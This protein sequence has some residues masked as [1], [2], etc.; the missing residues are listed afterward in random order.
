M[1][2][3]SRSPIDGT[4]T[5]FR[6]EIESTRELV[7]T[8][9][10]S[11]IERRHRAPD[12]RQ[13]DFVFIDSVD[14]VNV[15]ALTDADQVVLI[16]QYRHGTDA[17]TVEVPGGMVDRGEA[18][19]EACA[20][21]LLEETGF[22]GEAPVIIGRVTPNPAIQGNLCHTGLVRRARRVA[23][24][25]PDPLENIRVRLFPLDDVVGLIQRGII[26]HALVVAAFYHLG[27]FRGRVAL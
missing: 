2:E 15:V 27:L 23:E 6:W 20:R 25:T 24:P 5:V 13:G 17:V 22:A 7:R 18:P 4:D 8:P 19:A 21:E 14:W 12:G 16:E 3:R 11:L 1:T 10:F 9:I 26:H